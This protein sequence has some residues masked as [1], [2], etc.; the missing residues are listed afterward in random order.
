MTNRLFLFVIKR[1]YHETD[2]QKIDRQIVSF[3]L[4]VPWTD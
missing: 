2:N 1:Q 4:I 3:V